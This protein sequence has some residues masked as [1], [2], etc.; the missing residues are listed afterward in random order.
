LYEAHSADA[1]AGTGAGADTG[2]SADAME[3]SALWEELLGMIE[4]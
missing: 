1:D 2:A 4:Q 3:N